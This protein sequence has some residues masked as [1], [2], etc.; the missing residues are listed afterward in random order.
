MH[1]LLKK[2]LIYKLSRIFLL[3]LISIVSAFNKKSGLVYEVT[4]INSLNIRES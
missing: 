3:T 1:L 4:K 2:Q